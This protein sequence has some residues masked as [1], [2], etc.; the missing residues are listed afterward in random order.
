MEYNAYKYVF[1]GNAIFPCNMFVMSWDLF[2]QYCTWIFPII[3]ELVASIEIKEEWD[4]YSKRVIGFIAERL[5]TVWLVEKKYSL[6]ELE[7][8]Y[9]G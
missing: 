5:L 7:I 8:L 4:D 6:K 1:E 9:T 2:E 3:N